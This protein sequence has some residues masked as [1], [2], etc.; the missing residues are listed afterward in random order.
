MYFT[1]LTGSS[2]L[3]IQYNYTVELFIY[4]CGAK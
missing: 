2:I 4:T 3:K 1:S